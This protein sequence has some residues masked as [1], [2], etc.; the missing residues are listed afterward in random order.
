MNLNLLQFM[1]FAFILGWVGTDVIG[2]ASYQERMSISVFLALMVGYLN[3]GHG[4]T[5]RLFKLKLSNLKK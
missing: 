2:G 3:N 1:A 4:K 5:W